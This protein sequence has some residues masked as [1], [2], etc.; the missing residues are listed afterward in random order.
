MN[1]IK[2]SHQGGKI[3]INAKFTGTKNDQITLCVSDNGIGM[4]EE[5]KKCVFH[6]FSSITRRPNDLDDKS[7]SHMVN[8]TRGPGLGL[9]FCKSMIEQ[10]GGEIWFDSKDNEGSTFYIR[11]PVKVASQ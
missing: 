10:L 1:A 7:G 6:M 8:N 11:F 2:F 4:N 9:T 3:E 5:V